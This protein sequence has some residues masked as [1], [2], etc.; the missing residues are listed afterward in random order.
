MNK[1][2]ASKIKDIV[3]FNSSEFDPRNSQ[4][5]SNEAQTFQMAKKY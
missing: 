2:Y 1:T 3:D 4:L 5:H